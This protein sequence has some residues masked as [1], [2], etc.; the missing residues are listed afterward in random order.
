MSI[1]AHDFAFCFKVQRPT[2]SPWPHLAK[3]GP[4]DRTK[5]GTQQQPAAVAARRSCEGH[6]PSHPMAGPSPKKKN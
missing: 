2:L 4:G 6:Y 5:G 3:Q 1:Y